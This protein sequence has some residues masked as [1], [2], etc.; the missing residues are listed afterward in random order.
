MSYEINQT[1]TGFTVVVDGKLRGSHI[2]TQKEAEHQAK[3]LTDE[4]YAF[5]FRMI[6][7]DPAWA[8]KMINRGQSMRDPAY[9]AREAKAAHYYLTGHTQP[10]KG[11]GLKDSRMTWEGA[12]AVWGEAWK[13]ELYRSLAGLLKSLR[14]VEDREAIRLVTEMG[15]ALR[16]DDR[17]T[18]YDNLDQLM[19]YYG[20]TW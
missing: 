17:K 6:Q 2:K 3:L 8:A 5:T 13:D 4:N 14:R 1:P 10:K 12:E 19:E 7:K 20:E 9:Y 11:I 18:Y 16:H 15:R